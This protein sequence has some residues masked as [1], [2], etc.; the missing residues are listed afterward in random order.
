MPKSRK[1]S[2]KYAKVPHNTR[3]IS[4]NFSQNFAPGSRRGGSAEHGRPSAAQ[5]IPQIKCAKCDPKHAKLCPKHA[6]NMP[7]IWQ[8]MAK[9][10]QVSLNLSQRFAPGCGRRRPLTS[11][12]CHR[13]AY[14]AAAQD[15][16]QKFL[17]T[18]SWISYLCIIMKM[19]K[20]NNNFK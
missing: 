12:C 6:Q 14:P 1:V 11:A 9:C 15:T 4:L 2:V 18:E 13:G 5:N 10:G 19:I 7:K 3:Q 20:N 17:G 8:S 16:K